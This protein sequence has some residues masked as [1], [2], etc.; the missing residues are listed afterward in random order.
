MDKRK[1]IL[2]FALS[3]ML[4]FSTVS[5][6]FAVDWD[7]KS[8]YVNGNSSSNTPPGNTYLSSIG[9][10]AIMA[11]RF[12]FY[13]KNRNKLGKSVDIEIKKWK[14]SEYEKSF[15]WSANPKSHIELNDMYLALKQT[16]DPNAKVDT[17]GL[18]YRA[19]INRGIPLGRDTSVGGVIGHLHRLNPWSHQ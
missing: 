17:G 8:G 11:Y 7:G 3:I 1:R 2:C 9:T 10:E 14:D 4:I 18:I 15:Y 16:K 19:G 5:V 13:D 6:V 12:S